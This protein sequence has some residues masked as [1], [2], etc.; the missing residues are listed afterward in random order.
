MNSVLFLSIGILMF[1]STNSLSSAVGFKVG[2]VVTWLFIS[3]V[4]CALGLYSLRLRARLLYGAAELL[5]GLVITLVAISAYS[6]AQ[7]HEYVPIVGGGIFHKLPEGALQL[8]GPEI[9]LFGMLAAIYVL[10]RGLD[11]V[12]EGLSE[13]SNPKWSARWQRCFR[14][15]Q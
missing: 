6:A 2:I 14:K 12:G 7:S 5:F 11:N 15:H 1:F 3:L 8:S 4:F 9:A 13:L 10:V